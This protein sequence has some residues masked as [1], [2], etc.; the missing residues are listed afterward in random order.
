MNIYNFY[1]YNSSISTS[2]LPEIDDFELIKKEGFE[3]VIS[4]SM[5]SDS[6]TIKNEE[7]I[8][9]NL[10]MIYIHIPVDYYSPKVNDFEVFTTLLNTFKNKKLWIHCTKNYRVSLFMYLYNWVEYNKKDTKLLEKFWI[11]NEIWQKFI[12]NV[13]LKKHKVIT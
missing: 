13:I 2:G 11:P 6:K 3:I 9:T 12:D 7:L 8:L 1:R 5:P 4:L 10:D